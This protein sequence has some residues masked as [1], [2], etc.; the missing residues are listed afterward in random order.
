MYLSRRKT[1]SKRKRSSLE[2]VG[3]LVLAVIVVAIVWLVF[4][5]SPQ[6]PT[7]P[8]QTTT[9]A[10]APDFT[11]TDVNGTPIRLSDQRGKVVVL[12]FMRTT[13]P[14]CANE[15]SQL[16]SV[17]NQFGSDVTMISV[18]VDPQGDTN[19]ALKAYA[20]EH[21]APWVWARDTSN[22]DVASLYGIS[23]VPTIIIIDANGR[24]V[25]VN[26][27]ETSSSTLTQQIQSAQ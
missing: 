17:H 23:G 10:L 2:I 26:T 9:R 15:M 3:F 19:E 4:F 13:C 14:H 24:I 18:S 7:Q 6:N 12:E 22:N 27:G 1:K 16:A 20:E 21:N 25:Q 8:T 5:T 11:L